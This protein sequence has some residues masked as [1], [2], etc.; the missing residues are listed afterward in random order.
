MRNFDR[1]RFGGGGNRNFGKRDFGGNRHGGRPQLYDAICSNCGKECQVPFQP[2]GDK[3][4]YCRDCFAKM[5]GRES[6]NFGRNDRPVFHTANGASG[7]Q[8]LS[9]EQLREINNKLDKILALLGS[10]VQHLAEKAQ[11]SEAPVQN[12]EKRAPRAKKPVKK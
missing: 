6:G 4:V 3:P 5:N 9:G 1:N 8:S 7:N 2:T 10:S 11:E 12:E